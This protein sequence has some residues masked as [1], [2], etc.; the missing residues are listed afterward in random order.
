MKRFKEYQQGQ[1]MLLPPSLEELIDDNDMVRVVSRVVDTLDTKEIEEGFKGGGCPSYNPVMMLK[2]I[3]YAYGNKLYSSRQIAKALKRD[4]AFMWLSGMQQPDFNTINRFRSE[5]FK[6]SLSSVFAKVVGYLL[7]QGYIKSEDYFLDGT[8]LEADAGKY[9]H[10]WKANVIRYKQRV[11]KRVEDILAEVERINAEEDAIFEGKDLPEY[12]HGKTISSKEIA[13]VAE[14]INKELKRKDVKKAKTELKQLSQ[15]L[16]KYEEQEKILDGRNSYSKTDNDATFMYLKNDELRAAYNIQAASENGFVVG[17][18]VHQNSND[19]T[20]VKAHLTQR[21]QLGLPAPKRITADSIYGTEENYETLQQKK[22][23]SFLKYPTF[24]AECNGKKS[25]F[26]YDPK[27]D[28]YT[29]LTGEKLSFL[30]DDTEVTK[31]GY[32]KS[33]KVYECSD[34]RKCKFVTQCGKSNVRPNRVLHVNENLEHFK[35]LA[36]R[37]LSSP[38][39]L[40]LRKRR[41][42]EI[43]SIFGDIKHNQNYKRIRLRGMVKANIDL[44]WLFISSNIRKIHNKQ[45]LAIA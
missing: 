21:E 4:I 22:I 9:S 1:L 2:V 29:C 14:S 35:L 34:C 38:L 45:I 43:E 24:R 7:E 15:K 12:G 3:V 32:V 31:S 6:S 8:K 19:A 20:T 25:P 10:V 13:K 17:Y 23:D 40:S 18:S 5:Y 37:N 16:H 27:T 33:F 30:K 44:A 42:N 11:V 26:T 28:Q 39:G 36:R 41:S